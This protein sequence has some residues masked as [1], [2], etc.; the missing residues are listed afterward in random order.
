MTKQPTP[1]RPPKAVARQ[2]AWYYARNGY[3]RT[4]NER[5]ISE[6]GW[7]RYKKGEEVRLTANSVAELNRIRECLQ[8]AGFKPGR[9][10]R[11]G[12]QYRQPVYGRQAVARF[13]QIVTEESG[14]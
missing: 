14:A 3:V 9:P 12:N 4:Q 8:K 11:K 5:R 2:L 7:S 6:E 10:F 1:P 13:L